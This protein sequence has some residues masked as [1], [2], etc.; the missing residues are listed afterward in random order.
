MAF[1]PLVVSPL[2][3]KLLFV[4]AAFSQSFLFPT[5]TQQSERHW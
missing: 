2:P 5:N 1:E 4:D 3:T